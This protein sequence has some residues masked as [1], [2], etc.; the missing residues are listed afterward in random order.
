MNICNHQCSWPM[1]ISDMMSQ[2]VVWYIDLVQTKHEREE[3]LNPRI[4]N[5]PSQFVAQLGHEKQSERSTS[6]IMFI[7]TA[8]WKTE[9]PAFNFL[10]I[11]SHRILHLQKVVTVSQPAALLSFAS[12]LKELFLP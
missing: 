7:V 4:T 10:F 8:T 1:L 6:S 12:Y 9:D 2:L 3:K 11:C 5:S